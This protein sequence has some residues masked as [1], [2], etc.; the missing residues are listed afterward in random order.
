MARSWRGAPNLD[1]KALP[2]VEGGQHIIDGPR[3]DIRHGG[4]NA[5]QTEVLLLWSKLPADAFEFH[6]MYLPAGP[7]KAKIGDASEDAHGF[8]LRGCADVPMLA[9]SWVKPLPF[10]KTMFAKQ[11]RDAHMKGDFLRADNR[12]SARADFLAGGKGE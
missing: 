4:S 5:P 1:A 7:D 10:R 8:Q 9:G 11:L 6:E 3:H 2:F 12:R